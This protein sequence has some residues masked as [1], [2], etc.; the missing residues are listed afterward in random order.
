MAKTRADETLAIVVEAGRLHS[1]GRPGDAARLLSG[2]VRARP[3]F[4]PGALAL[5]DLLRWRRRAGAEALY[6]SVLRRAP[7]D[8]R[9]RRGLAELALERAAGCQARGRWELAEGALERAA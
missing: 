8:A 5:A 7:A 3:D 6:R 2:L 9:A 4:L 1:A